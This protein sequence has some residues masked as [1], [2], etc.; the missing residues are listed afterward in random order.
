[1]LFDIVVQKAILDKLNLQP[2][3]L[4]TLYLHGILEMPGFDLILGNEDKVT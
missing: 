4:I 2:P 3:D 1:V